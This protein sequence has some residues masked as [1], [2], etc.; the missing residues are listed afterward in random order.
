MNECYVGVISKIKD[1]DRL[2]FSMIIDMP[3]LSHEEKEMLKDH[4]T[5]SR[6]EEAENPII[7]FWFNQ[8]K[9]KGYWSPWMEEWT[10]ATI[11]QMFRGE[12]TFNV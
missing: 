7:E 9:A 8:A 6:E 5:I 1:W 3:D 4:V 10:T 11:Y 12:E 2:S